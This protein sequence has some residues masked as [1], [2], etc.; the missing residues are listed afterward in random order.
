MMLVKTSSKYTTIG[1]GSVIAASV[2]REGGDRTWGGSL[3]AY[4][5]VFVQRCV[6][7]DPAVSHQVKSGQ[8]EQ[9]HNDGCRRDDA[10][11]SARSVFDL[12]EVA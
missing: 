5:G 8:I 12:S 9:R 6:I 1:M 4:T 2:R 10:R 3:E 11:N 7:S